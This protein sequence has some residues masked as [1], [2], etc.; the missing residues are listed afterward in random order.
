MQLHFSV[1]VFLI[2]LVLLPSCKKPEEKK[3]AVDFS[4]RIQIPQD[5]QLKNS[6]PIRIAIAAMISP[7]E[8]A[9]YYEQM[10]KYVSRKLERPVNITQKKTYDEVNDMLER[11]EL[12]IAFVCSGPYVIGKKKFS[13]ELLVAPML[14]G[15]PF[16]QAY[17]IVHKDS[18][19]NDIK[20][21]KGKRFAFTDPASNT[22]KLVPTYILSKMG[23]DPEHYF[24]EIIF[25]YGH[26]NSIKAVSKG[27]VDGASV[28]GLI[29]DY[30]QDKNPDFIS[31]TKI[32]FK[33]PLYGIPPVVVHPQLPEAEKKEIKKIFLTL[34]EDP[35]GKK[36]LSEL[37]IEKFIVP[38]DA[39]Y[40]S[41]REMQ[42]WIDR[43]N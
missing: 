26:D 12:D 34:H 20:E 14:Y 30:Y 18:P 16:Y 35:E 36:I 1:V 24:K 8:T 33:S 11:K 43:Q 32:I 4:D 3:A 39:S 15:K 31:N 29:W 25:T 42:S 37:L 13:M 27:L 40:N 7:K 6:Q 28:D 21:L 23:T 2:A 9:Q 22:G 41:I 19:V 10:M 17:F 38:D 5:N